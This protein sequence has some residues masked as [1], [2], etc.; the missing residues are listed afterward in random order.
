MSWSKMIHQYLLR[1]KQCTILLKKV[2]GMLEI[3]HILAICLLSTLIVFEVTKT[4]LQMWNNPLQTALSIDNLY[5]SLE[6]TIDNTKDTQSLQ[7]KG[8]F[9]EDLKPMM[10]LPLICVR[11]KPLYIPKVSSK[12]FLLS[13]K[14]SVLSLQDLNTFSIVSFQNPHHIHV[15]QKPLYNS[16]LTTTPIKSSLSFFECFHEVCVE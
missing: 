11:P 5:E 10:L 14:L 9:A 8:V 3:C 15:L 7:I 12:T 16:A 13:L 6:S 1:R 4:P 2:S